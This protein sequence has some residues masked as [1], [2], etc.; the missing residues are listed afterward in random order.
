MTIDI[1]VPEAGESITQVELARWLV[2]DGSYVE[3]DQ[4][5]AEIDSDKATLTINAD[6][7]GTIQIMVEEGTTVEPGKIIGRIRV[8]EVAGKTAD[9]KTAKQEES[10]PDVARQAKQADK[11]PDAESEPFARPKPVAETTPSG[12]QVQKDFTLSPAARKLLEQE[13]LTASLEDINPTGKRITKKDILVALAAELSGRHDSTEK[14]EKGKAGLTQ[15]VYPAIQGSWGGTRQVE[16]QKMSTLRKKVAERLVAVKNQTAMLTTFNEA[17]ISAIIALR[18]QYKERFEEKYGVKLGFMSFFVKAVTE[19]IPFFPQ[20]NGYI[21]GNQIILPDYADVGIAVSTPK[22]LMVPVIRNAEQRSIFELEHI[23]NEMAEKAR[24]NKIT[25]EELTG[26]T[27]SITNGGVFGSMLSTPIINP[28]QSAIL[29]MHNIIE[30][31]V[32]IRGKVEIRPMMYLALSY[33]HRIIDGKESVSFLVKVKEFIE[34]PAKMLFGGQE[35][36]ETLLGL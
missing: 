9:P 33:D 16:R 31:P 23:I 18:N 35:A 4:D 26:G 17:D 12:N 7:S 19:S 3:K 13:G 36:G 34:N 8:G 11:E 32:A 24:N 1:R 21:D 20:V 30:R 25:I 28:P 2:E 22:G 6:D 5:I 10:Q 29:G 15:P 27:F 14:T